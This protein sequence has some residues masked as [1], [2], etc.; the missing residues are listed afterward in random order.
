M[1]FIMT[2]MVYMFV[3]SIFFIGLKSNYSD[4]SNLNINAELL[5]NRLS[6][7]YDPDYSFL[8]ASKVNVAR[9]DVLLNNYDPNKGYE[10]F[11]KDFETTTYSKIDYCVY[12]ENNTEII[13]NFAAWSEHRTIEEYSVFINSA[14]CGSNKNLVYP[15]AVVSCQDPRSDSLILSKPVLFGQDIIKLS[16]VICAEKK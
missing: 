8:S 13:K 2:F 12:L 7:V 3:L 11:F 16:V 14:K 1:D 5:F 9:F 4:S 15:E 6:N 10:L